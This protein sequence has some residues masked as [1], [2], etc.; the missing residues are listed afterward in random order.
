MARAGLLVLACV[1]SGAG[2][3]Q[4]QAKDLDHAVG[5]FVSKLVNEGRLSGQK[6]YVGADDFFEEENELRLPLSDILRTMS[7][8]A[9]TD[10]Q[11]EVALVQAEA[12]QVLHGRWRWESETH[13]HLTLFIADPPRGGGEPLVRQSAEALV[14][15]VSLRRKYI[16]PTLRHW[17]D[18]VVRRL[19][20]NLTGSGRFRLHLAPL[21]GQDEAL[22]EHF[23]AYLLD[24]WRPAFTGNARFTLVD[25]AESAEGVLHGEVFVVGEHVEVGLRI[26]DNKGTEVAADHVGMSRA[27]FPPGMLPPY[28]PRGL[29]A[30]ESGM[31]MLAHK[32]LPSLLTGRPSETYTPRG[33]IGERITFERP[34]LEPPRVVVALAGVDAGKDENLRIWIDLGEIQKDGFQYNFRTW[35]DTKIYHARMHWIA[36]GYR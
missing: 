27:V 16:E 8:R 30:I 4:L 20:R 36:F 24:R 32:K 34:F 33:L 15:V 19:E 25:S 14:P 35:S 13:L 29:F 18:R 22:P 21:S 2:Y 11:V 6:V 3:A 28:D 9:L 12:V 31:V 1:F 5:E 26:V 7:L 10:R 23:S 17:G